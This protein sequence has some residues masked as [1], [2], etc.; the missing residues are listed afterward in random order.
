MLL[1]FKIQLDNDGTISVTPATAPADANP[2]QQGAVRNLGAAYQAAA[3]KSGTGGPISGPGTGAPISGPGTGAP[4]SGSPATVLVLG[5]I[6]ICGS[7]PGHAGT[8]GTLGGGGPISGPG[9]GLP[10]NGGKDA[11]EKGQAKANAPNQAAKVE[12]P[13]KSRAARKRA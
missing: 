11:D 4:I 5:P 3:Q 2:N 12:A 9:T 13:K 6:V 7:G 10:A 1:E 8:G